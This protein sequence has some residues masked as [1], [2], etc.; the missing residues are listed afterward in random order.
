MGKCFITENG[1]NHSLYGRQGMEIRM[2]SEVFLIASDYK[3]EKRCVHDD[4]LIEAKDTHTHILFRTDR[5]SIF[6][7]NERV[8][9]YVFKN[10]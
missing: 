10:A 6:T 1:K 9:E 3:S 8:F 7:R 4:V 2:F 5:K